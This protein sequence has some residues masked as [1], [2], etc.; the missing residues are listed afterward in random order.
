MMYYSVD[1]IEGNTAVLEDDDGK[2]R[3]IELLLLPE[4]TKES[5]VLFEDENGTF[6][7]DDEEKDRR[8]K[9]ILEM[10]ENL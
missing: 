8:Q 7:K 4:N 10:L 6:V 1:R 5:D 3:S 9:L 2:R